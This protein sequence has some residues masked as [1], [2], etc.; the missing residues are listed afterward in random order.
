MRFGTLPSPTNFQAK[1][2][3]TLYGLKGVACIADDILIFGCGETKE[4]ADADNDRNI[5]ALLDR[6]RE[7]GLHLTK[8]KLQL[9]RKSTIF[10]GHELTT[11]GLRPNSRKGQAIKEM[12][13]PT[14]KPGVV[15]LLGMATYLVNLYRIFRKLHQSFEMYNVLTQNSDGVIQFTGKHSES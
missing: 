12:P 4:E 9:R 13:P 3:E 5:I 6:C 10:M 14:D 1:M 15:R 7:K 8:E 11:D 2:H